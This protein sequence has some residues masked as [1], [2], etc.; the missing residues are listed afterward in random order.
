MVQL[1]TRDSSRNATPSQV[2]SAPQAVSNDLFLDSTTCPIHSGK[3]TGTGSQL[4][5]WAEKENGAP[6]PNVILGKVTIS[7]NF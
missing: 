7:R 3:S 4:K 1:A 6:L 2:T 5:G